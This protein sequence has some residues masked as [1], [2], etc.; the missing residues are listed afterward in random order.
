MIMN[1]TLR[2]TSVVF[3]VVAGVLNPNT[4]AQAT[5]VTDP[6][7]QFAWEGKRVTLNVTA[8]GAVPLSYQWQF[9]GTNIAD[10]TNR[11]LTMAQ[12][13][14]TN[15]GDY[16]IVVAD[17]T[18]TSTSQVAR[19]I[20]RAWPQPTGPHIPELARLDTNMQTVMQANAVPGGSL[21][22]VKDGRL[23]LARAYGF[24]EVENGEPYQPDSLC[25][26]ASMS[27]LIT[28][29]AAVKLAEKGKFDLDADSQPNLLEYAHGTD[30]RTPS[31]PSRLSAAYE[32]V[33]SEL[34]LRVSF[35]RLPIAQE[36]AYTL[37]ASDDLRTWMPLSG[38]ATATTL[39]GAGT[40]TAEARVLAS[41]T[42]A[43]RFV[44]LRV[45]RQ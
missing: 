31:E 34:A 17:P 30:P 27:K 14:L 15:D 25:R 32:R 18:G 41:E 33:G 10:A 39:N 9:K 29:A 28:A 35:R 42:S 19:V 8:K 11:S 2:L 24:A 38:E 26:I 23:V 12:V 4:R 36:V 1:T 5:I 44:R 20:V 6:R 40:V 43:R 22:V 37:E 13:A 45:S 7:T 21:A 3:V 16:R